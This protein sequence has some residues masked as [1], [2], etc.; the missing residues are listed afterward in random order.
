MQDLHGSA[1]D[2]AGHLYFY[3]A[4]HGASVPEWREDPVLIASGMV[5]AVLIP[6]GIAW[7]RGYPAR[8]RETH[9]KGQV[10]FV[11]ACL[12]NTGVRWAE[13]PPA[14]LGSG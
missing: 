7:L 9:F 1:P 10:F 12:A 6:G 11:D 4:G 3:Y 5:H 2:K 8:T 14:D 13:P